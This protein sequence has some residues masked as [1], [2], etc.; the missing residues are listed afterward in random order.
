MTSTLGIHHVWWCP[1]GPLAFLPIHAAGVYPSGPKLSDF[2]V[3]SYTPTLTALLNKSE[4]HD[5]QM[6]AKHQLLTVALPAES[7]LPGTK[8]EVEHVAQHAEQF[9]V[10]SLL[11]SEATA[12]NVSEAMKVSSW[13]HFACHGAQ[14]SG[15]PTE[16]CLQLAKHSKLTLSEIIK[17]DLQN[18]ELAFLS[19]CET[20]TGDENLEEEAVHLAGG[21]LL[22]GYRGVIATMW[23][24]DDD[25]AVEVADKT[26]SL[27]FQ[28]YNADSTHAAEALHFAI[29][30]VQEDLEAK[31]KSSLFKL[32][33]FIHMGI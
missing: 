23:T 18:A 15:R 2:V 16:S 10:L 17:L 5:V 24:I 29:K 13:V 6:T 27:L 12:Q 26:Y 33:P 3:S 14:D 7:R 28:K 20:A 25:V 30:E 8:K 11:E 22:A 9:S 21:M 31:G 4:F 1:T 19:A 32:I